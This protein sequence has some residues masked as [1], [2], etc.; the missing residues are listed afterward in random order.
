MDS[1]L[2]VDGQGYERQGREV[3][4]EHKFNSES[5]SFDQAVDQKSRLNDFAR[6]TSGWFWE[7][8]ENLRFVYFSPTFEDVTGVAPEWHYGK[9]REDLG[10]PQSVEAE[11]WR[12]HLET[13][14]RGD[15]F[16]DFVFQRSG[17][18]G[19]KWM[20]TSG[21]PVFSESGVFK[22]YRGTATDVTA[23]VLAEQRGR[24]LAESIEHI[25]ESFVLWDS[26][27][28]LVSCN[29]RFRQINAAVIDTTLPGTLFEE[30]VRAAMG[31]G[32]YPQ[33]VGREE[34]WLAERIERHRNP[35]PPMLMERQN[36]IW[37]QV[38][39]HQLPNGAVATIST[40]V[41]ESQ[42][43]RQELEWLAAN[44]PLTLVLNRRG[45]MDLARAEFVRAQRYG[46]PLSFLMLDID[47][48]KRLNDQYGHGVGD[49]ALVTVAKVCQDTQ[50]DSDEIGRLGG[51]EFGVLLPET[52][53][54]SAVAVAER[55]R[56]AVETQTGPAFTRYGPVTISIGVACHS[57]EHASLDELIKTADGALYEAKRNGRNRAEMSA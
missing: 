46:R 36:G 13:L 31:A 17:P 56:H 37:I 21:V 30:H 12:A 24:V 40:D 33:A 8:D 49:E 45:F 28:R 34:E 48:F 51:E 39:D 15:P 44:D 26:D 55:L 42:R 53:A 10:I 27:D 25:S 11:Q 4:S 5:E 19:L 52:G 47:N 20:Q 57:A 29:A 50:R 9:T 3:M 32:L 54:Q 23:H 41:T 18:D 43:L 7:M 1:H 22:G 35:G 6:S 16:R 2:F 38:A 14:N